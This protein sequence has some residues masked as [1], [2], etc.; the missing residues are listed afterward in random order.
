MMIKCGNCSKYHFSTMDVRKCCEGHAV[1]TRFERVTAQ[2]VPRVTLGSNPANTPDHAVDV[3]DRVP[4]YFGGDD[5]SAD[6]YVG[7]IYSGPPMD[8]FDHLAQEFPDQARRISPHRMEENYTVNHRPGGG[9][10]PSEKQLKFLKDLLAKKVHDFD[11]FDPTTLSKRECSQM[12]DR[13][14][15]AQWKPSGTRL[16][17][18]GL[19]ETPDGT[20][21]LVYKSSYVDAVLAKKLVLTQAGVGTDGK[22]IWEGDWQRASG[23]QYKMK[24]DWA[25]SFD[26]AAEFGRAFGICMRCGR[27]LENEDSIA[28]GIGPKCA[29]YF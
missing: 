24:A 17:E 13:L 15:K 25:V 7:A 20:I 12:I 1:D 27:I 16:A 11:D 22:T 28:R 23:F 21:V 9:D 29:Q 5:P 10:P 26:R 2:E 18:P 6:A 3:M 8:E 4:Q 14:K 19:Y